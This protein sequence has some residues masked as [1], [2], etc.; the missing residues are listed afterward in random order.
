[1]QPQG[2]EAKVYPISWVETFQPL[3]P[4]HGEEARETCCFFLTEIALTQLDRMQPLTRMVVK[5]AA[6]I[7][8][9]FTTQLLLHILPTGLR[10]HMNSSLD[11]L[12]SDNILRWLKNTEV[13]EDVQD[14]TEGPA[15]SSQVESG[16]W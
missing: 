14:P 7:G 4:Q 15:T 6:I 9:V 1:M 10:T 8:P 3:Q 12:V 16:K 5:F 11:E 13:P 2:E